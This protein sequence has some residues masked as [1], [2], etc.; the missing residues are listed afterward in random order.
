MYIVT[1]GEFELIKLVAHD[2]HHSNPDDISAHTHR[3][4]VFTSR[5]KQPIGI[6]RYAFTLALAGQHHTLGF[7]DA[8]YDLLNR[9]H[10]CKEEQPHDYLVEAYHQAPPRYTLAAKCLGQSAEVIVIKTVDFLKLMQAASNE[11]W[12]AII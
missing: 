5:F 4:E 6:K 9:Y 3:I 10:Q 7:E 1:H 2:H 12:E 8:L 11:V